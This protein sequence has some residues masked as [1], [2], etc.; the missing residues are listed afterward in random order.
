MK[1]S[2]LR[3]KVHNGIFAIVMV[4]LRHS[5]VKRKVIQFITYIIQAKRIFQS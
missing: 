3:E 5:G 2:M 4:F 1:M